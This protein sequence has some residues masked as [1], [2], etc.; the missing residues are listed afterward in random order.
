MQN[1]LYN[2]NVNKINTEEKIK[3]EKINQTLENMCK[4]GN[5]IKKEII[6]EK[7][8]NPEKFIET[9]EALK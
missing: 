9:K 5:I 6:K 8:K 1:Y 4:L 3:N 2:N 7:K